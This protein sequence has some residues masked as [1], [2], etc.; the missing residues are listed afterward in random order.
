MPNKRPLLARMVNPG[1][2][3]WLAVTCN[4]IAVAALVSLIVNPTDNLVA[5]LAML[6]PAAL[7]LYGTAAILHIKQAKRNQDACEDARLSL[8]QK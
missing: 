2:P 7:A 5:A 8:L 3:A 4:A 1:V 6:A